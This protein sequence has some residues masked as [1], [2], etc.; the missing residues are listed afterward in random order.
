MIMIRI[1]PTPQHPNTL[2]TDSHDN[3]P[4]KIYV[5]PSVS[6]DIATKQGDDSD[7]HHNDDNDDNDQLIDGDDDQKDDDYPAVQTPPVRLH[8]TAP[9]TENLESQ[10]P[11]QQ[12]A[13]KPVRF[14]RP[15]ESIPTSERSH[16]YS[17]RENPTPS[18]RYQ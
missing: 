13:K 11:Q 2:P 4:L 15:K 18:K 17:L 8:G 3:A 1:T 7:K 14:T 9:S 12:K 5:K 6:F 16:K 10:P